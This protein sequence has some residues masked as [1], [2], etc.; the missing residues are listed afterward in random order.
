[1]AYVPMNRRRALAIVH[2]PLAYAPSR[3]W[4]AAVYLM[5]SPEPT[6]YVQCLAPERW[7]GWG[8]AGRFAGSCGKLRTAGTPETRA[9]QAE[10]EGVS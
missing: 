2:Q 8:Q 6:E 5:Q 4:E 9:G 3:V 7:S 10:A 1:M